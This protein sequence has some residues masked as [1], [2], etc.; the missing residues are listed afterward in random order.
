MEG[1]AMNLGEKGTSALAAML[2]LFLY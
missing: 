1:N 2:A